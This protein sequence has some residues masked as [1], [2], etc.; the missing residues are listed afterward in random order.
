MDFQIAL[1]L[2]GRLSCLLDNLQRFLRCRLG[3]VELLAELLQLPEGFIVAFSSHVQSIV[4]AW[5]RC[6]PNKCMG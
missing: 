1:G 6:H 5:G 3:D 4:A 2:L